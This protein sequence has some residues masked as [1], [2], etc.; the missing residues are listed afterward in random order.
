MQVF[1]REQ[2]VFAFGSILSPS[3]NP[4]TVKAR[5]LGMKL[6]WQNACLALHKAGYDSKQLYA[7]SLRCG[8]KSVGDARLELHLSPKVCKYPQAPMV[9]FREVNNFGK[10]WW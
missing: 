8:S 3:A 5:A 10:I 7:Q 4:A 9:G 6:I 1:E 2:A